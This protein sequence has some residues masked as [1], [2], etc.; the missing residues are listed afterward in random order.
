MWRSMFDQA[1][2]IGPR[3]NGCSR[4][5]H[6]RVL[7][8][9]RDP[10]GWVVKWSCYDHE[11]MTMK[12]QIGCIIIALV[13]CGAAPAPAQTTASTPQQEPLKTNRGSVTLARAQ[14]RQT[15]M[16]KHLSC[17]L[18]RLSSSE[19]VAIVRVSGCLPGL[20][21]IRL[22]WLRT[23]M[24]DVPFSAVSGNASPTSPSLIASTI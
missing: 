8:N 4:T 7:L 3:G 16:R 15:A 12:N 13:L 2:S 24:T 1:V 11:P 20:H 17:T 19:P 23:G 5:Y 14:D 22:Y 9:V 6:G 10:C 21:P 18:S